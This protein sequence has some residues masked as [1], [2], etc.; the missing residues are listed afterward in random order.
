MPKRA[1]IATVLTVA[2]LALLLSFKTPQV[3]TIAGNPQV[4]G[5]TSQVGGNAQVAGQSAGTKSSY[6][7][8]V[9]GSAVQTPY[10]TVQVQVTIQNGK[11]TDV[12]PLQMPSDRSY[13]VQIAQYAAPLLR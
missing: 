11:I 2:A 5:N 12:T 3:P 6:S 8:Q 10:G 9:S 4:G 13:S 1:T 7:G